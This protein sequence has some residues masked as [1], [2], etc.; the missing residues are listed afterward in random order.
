[1]TL[2]NI[3]FVGGFIID[4]NDKTTSSFKDQFWDYIYKHDLSNGIYFTD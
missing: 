4:D 3:D 1:M 2:V